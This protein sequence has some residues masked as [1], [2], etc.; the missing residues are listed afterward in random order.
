MEK[1]LANPDN[2]VESHASTNI[3]CNRKNIKLDRY[4]EEAKETAG[5][6]AAEAKSEM[7]QGKK[8]QAA[9]K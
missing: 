1:I 5:D 2:T 3:K 8:A 9:K 6:I 4:V 7:S